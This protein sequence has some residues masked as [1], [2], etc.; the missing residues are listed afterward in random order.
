[1]CM[2]ETAWNWISCSSCWREF[3]SV[4]SRGRETVPGFIFCGN[5]GLSFVPE[6]F[7]GERFDHRA[8]L[9]CVEGQAGFAAGLFQEGGSIPVVL[10]RYLREQQPA[11]SGHA[12]QQAMATDLDRVGRNWLWGRQDAQ[13]NF[14]MRGFGQRYRSESRVFESR[15]A[16]RVRYRTIDRAHR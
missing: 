2:R 5:F 16:R 4:R 3:R 12:D 7:C 9:P 6:D 15:G 1:M 8:V 13:L 11:P 10:D 14:E